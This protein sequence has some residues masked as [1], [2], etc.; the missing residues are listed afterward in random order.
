ME[1][2][3]IVFPSDGEKASDIIK[4]DDDAYVPCRI[5]NEMMGK[6]TP[7]RKYCFACGN[8]ACTDHGAFIGQHAP[9]K[10]VVCGVKAN[11]R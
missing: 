1:S 8:A 10:C 5:C 6:I 2:P 3:K 4:N 9:F 7:T 11:Y